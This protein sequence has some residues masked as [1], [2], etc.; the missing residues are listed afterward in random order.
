[1]LLHLYSGSVKLDIPAKSDRQM[2]PIPVNNRISS[3]ITADTGD[4]CA[5]G[6][7]TI[8]NCP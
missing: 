1:M 7:R 5:L 8:T 4:I 2:V 6:G 3:N